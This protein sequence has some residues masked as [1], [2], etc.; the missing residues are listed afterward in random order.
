ML[1]GNSSKTSPTRRHYFRK[2]LVPVG[3]GIYPD[4]LRN[5]FQLAKLSKWLW[6][7]EIRQKTHSRWRVRPERNLLRPIVNV[8]GL[9][10][11]VEC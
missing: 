6:V 10:F 5:E 7:N 11:R 4:G 8:P 2:F 9:R 3:S 1:P